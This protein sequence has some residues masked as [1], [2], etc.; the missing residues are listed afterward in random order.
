[1]SLMLGLVRIAAYGA[2]LLFAG[3]AD[4]AE[5]KMIASNAVKETY[6]QLLP[7]FEKASGHHVAVGWIG[8]DDVV[9]RIGGGEVAD[10]VIAPSFTIDDLIRA[11]KLAP[12]SRVDVA[13]S[14]IGVALRPGAPKP[15]LSSA[16]GLKKYL[17]SVKSIIISGG[18]S[19]TYLTALFQRWGITDQIK[20][21]TKRLGPG[22][23]PGV[24]VARGDGDIGF[25]Q[26]SELLAVKGIDYLGP[27]PGDVQQV[28]IFSAGIHKSAPQAEAARALIRFVTAP[29]A[30]PVLKKTG[31]EPG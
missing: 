22:E 17:L 1:M 9:R 18:P 16:E 30:I 6:L 25:T 23:S 21:K 24:A 31:L 2:L 11:G 10:V 26:V 8:T 13:H 15:D 12:G 28:T 27:I 5:I 7:G 3:R 29:A 4:A 20:S 19:G 14:I